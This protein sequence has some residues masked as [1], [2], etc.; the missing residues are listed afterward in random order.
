MQRPEYNRQDFDHSPMIVFYETTRACDL[1]C[2]H[3]RA[4]AQR[5]C[6]PDELTTSQARTLIEQLTKFPRPPLLVLTGGDPLKRG[7]VF[8]LVDHARRQGLAVAMTP[9][10]TPLVTQ[11]SLVRLKQSGLHR[12]AVSL[13]GADAE[14]HDGFRGV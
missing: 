4:D 10:A 1:R 13:D 5:Q 14:T 3:C 8:D 7:D 9:S 6:H 12:L 11:E 2:S